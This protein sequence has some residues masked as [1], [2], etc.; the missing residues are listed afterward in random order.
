MPHIRWKPF[1]AAFAV[2]ALTL[3]IAVGPII[4]D[5]DAKRRLDAAAG[6]DAF[7]TS[8]DS[9]AALVH[10]VVSSTLSRNR[11]TSVVAG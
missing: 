8:C 7:W 2:L 1:V 11:L 9:A 4:Q 5:V 3:A 10:L 6:T